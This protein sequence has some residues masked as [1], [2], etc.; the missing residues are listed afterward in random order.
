MLTKDA[1]RA[2]VYF[3]RRRAHYKNRRGITQRLVNVI[4]QYF[5]RHVSGVSIRGLTRVIQNYKKENDVAA[6]AA[7]LAFLMLLALMHSGI[8][9]TNQ[10]STEFRMSADLWL[11]SVSAKQ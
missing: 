1:R 3:V 10:Y 9:T 5:V 6:T 2:I 11:T 4:M 7:T 8:V